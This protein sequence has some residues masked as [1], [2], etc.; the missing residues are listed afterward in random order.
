MNAIPDAN[1]TIA[2]IA[3]PA[4]PGG[5]GV[6]RVSGPQAWGVGRALFVP[7]RPWGAAGPRPWRLRLGRVVEPA[8]GEAI[9]EA[10]AA[11][12]RA[13]RSYT[14]QD[15]VELSLHGGPALLRRALAAAL[16]EGCRLA[17]PGEFTLRAF[18]GGRLDLAQAEA[19]A[20]LV[21]AQ[22]RG[23][24]RLA[25]AALAGGLGQRLAPVR[26]A[27]LD[28]AAAVEAGIDFPEDVA[29]ADG[30]GLAAR[31]AL[32]A[33]EPL[34]G[35]VEASQRRRVFREGA[36]V[37]I[38]GRPNVGKSSLF[39][40]LLGR[41]RALVSELAG[42]TRDCIEEG[43]ILGGA[44]VRLIDTAGLGAGVEAHG[45]AAGLDAL[46]RAAAG[47]ALEAADLALVVLDGSQALTAEDRA[48]LAA[49]AGRPR[50][51]AVNKADL[52]AAWELSDL[53]AGAG[54]ALRVS[55][56]AGAGLAGLSE[57]LAAAITGGEPEPAAGEVLA[58]ARQAQALERALEATRRAAGHLAG[59]EPALELASLDLAEALAAL[60]EV[61]GRGAPEEVFEAVFSQFCVGK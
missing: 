39:N 4:G 46:G 60:G 22:G 8:T 29:P 6:L 14:T 58:G 32:Q 28:A 50:L 20:G 5:L 7:R 33:A 19:V 27:L 53:P 38:C 9:D 3:T 42:T 48:V 17:R 52:G 10:L 41:G 15:C 1:D 25:L 2:A 36:A 16:H 55:A 11:F 34:A 59:F 35:L 57:R 37:V 31:L 40:A 13:P 24:A 21:A 44:A 26:A 18:L 56:T 61:D 30:P 23:E 51:I 12:F 54:P 43:L 49:S 47:A 45:P